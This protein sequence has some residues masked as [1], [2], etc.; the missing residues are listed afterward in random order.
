MAEAPNAALTFETVEITGTIN[1]QPA[2]AHLFVPPTPTLKRVF[3]HIEADELVVNWTDRTRYEVADHLNW[4]Q[5]YGGTQ[6]TPQT[7][8]E[9]RY[10]R[11]TG[12]AAFTTT[13]SNILVTGTGSK[14]PL[15]NFTAGTV[16]L[17]ANPVDQWVGGSRTR[18]TNPTPDVNGTAIYFPLP[19]AATQT[20]VAQA[21]TTIEGNATI[22]LW[23]TTVNVVSNGEQTPY[24]SGS[25]TRPLSPSPTADAPARERHYRLITVHATNA[26]IT[27]VIEAGHALLASQTVSLTAA[28]YADI[29]AATGPLLVGQVSRE[30]VDENVQ[31]GGAFA[32][33]AYN[34]STEKSLLRGSVVFNQG[35]TVVTADGDQVATVAS[36]GSRSPASWWMVVVTGGLLVLGAVGFRRFQP[37]RI[38][39]VELAILG[40][41]H[42]R[43]RRLVNRLVRRSPGDPDVVFL[44]GTA[45]LQD[46]RHERLIEKVEP[47]AHALK[48]EDRRGVAFLL[49]VASHAVKDEARSRKWGAEASKDPLLATQLA[50]SGIAPKTQ[51]TPSS[52]MNAYV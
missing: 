22:I 7:Q 4:S 27:I 34:A 42:R 19:A 29:N 43:A 16:H 14:A 5:P 6:K 31:V 20:R 2:P 38:E 37:V 11:A 24:E 33:N 17:E 39:Q 35:P 32:L 47:L 8:G 30:L 18:G 28:G 3:L 41:Q 44:Y 36:P 45:L 26:R 10:P 1:G 15:V 25:W 46:A 49:A 21:T 50:K 23:D 13:S 9:K 51:G 48:V 40:G 52:S 12:D